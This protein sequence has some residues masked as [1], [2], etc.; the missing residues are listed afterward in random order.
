ME[1]KWRSGSRFPVDADIAHK[2]IERIR[3]KNG[4]E[5]LPEDVV[6][7]ASKARNP[8][9]KAFEWDDS[10]AANEHRLATARKIL[11]S[12]VVVRGELSTDRPQRVYEVVTKPAAS[13]EEKPRK[14]YRTAED[15][16][17][18]PEMRAEVL[19]R[20]LKELISFRQRY[21]DLQELAIVM[22]NIDE[23]CETIEV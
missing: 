11:H 14:V 22:R 18:D 20:A 5:A 15:I 16:M 12:I 17:K 9:H 23:L 2:E 1:V 6:E 21:R 8:L 7:A 3:I 19:Q 13:S 4:G 10:I